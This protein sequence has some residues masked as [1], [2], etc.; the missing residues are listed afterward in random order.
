MVG[1]RTAVSTGNVQPRGL[2]VALR[3]YC[4]MVDESYPMRVL[5]WGFEE[6]RFPPTDVGASR[7]LWPA[8]APPL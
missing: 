2:K 5:P 7:P 3:I 4:E 6:R 8:R 1:M